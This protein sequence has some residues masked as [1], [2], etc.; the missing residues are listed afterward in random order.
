MVD[1]TALI[2]VEGV[3]HVESSD[4]LA[5]DIFVMRDQHLLTVVKLAND[6]VRSE[7]MVDCPFFFRHAPPGE[8]HLLPGCAIRDRLIFKLVMALRT[9]ES[10]LDELTIVE[11]RKGTGSQGRENCT[12]SDE[13]AL[14]RRHPLYQLLCVHFCYLYS[15]IV[16]I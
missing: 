9:L 3:D 10:L 8:V 6:E 4:L 1:L 2:T 11:V 14:V 7:L 16:L 12:F 13:I 15:D 5:I